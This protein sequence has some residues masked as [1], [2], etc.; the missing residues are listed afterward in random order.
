RSTVPKINLTNKI[1]TMKQITNFLKM[2]TVLLLLGGAVNSKAQTCAANF[3]FTNLP[4]GVVSFSSTS[5]ATTSVTAYYWSFGNNTTYTAMGISG[6]NTSTTYTANGAYVV[7][8]FIMSTAPSC[9]SA[10]Q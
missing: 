6:A 7:Q 9:S 10:I 1:K 4:N 3:S 8:L 2:L 5:I